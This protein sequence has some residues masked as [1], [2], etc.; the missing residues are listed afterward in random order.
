[1]VLRLDPTFPGARRRLARMLLNATDDRVREHGVLRV[2]EL[3]DAELEAASHPTSGPNQPTAD[4][5]FDLGQTLL[6]A[7]RPDDARRV[8][9]QLVLSRASDLHALHLYS[10]ACFTLGGRWR[11]AG[12]EACR[13]VLRL[14]P[15]FVP[16]IHN[17][18]VAYT[19]MRQWNR[20]RYWVRQGLRVEPEDTSLRRLRF[21]L[22][23]SLIAEAWQAGK[24]AARLLIPTRP[25]REH[26]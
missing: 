5:L 7:K 16:A 6:D 18:A 21:K 1:M 4:D 24:F 8:L 13:G 14:D 25:T 26:A 17:M 9:G 20:A 15:R 19:Q 12:I 22:R 10:V 23:L 11:E 3:L 2:R